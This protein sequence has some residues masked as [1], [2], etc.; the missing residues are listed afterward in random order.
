MTRS[1]VVTTPY[2]TVHLLSVILTGI[3]RV[4][5]TSYPLPDGT[6]AQCDPDG[7]NLCS[8]SSVY[9]KC[10]N[11]TEHCSCELCTNY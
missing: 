5:V 11:T 6:P 4:V 8:N 10:G 2:L 3:N 7:E 9:G 1:V